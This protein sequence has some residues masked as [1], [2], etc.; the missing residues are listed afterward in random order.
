MPLDAD[1]AAYLESRRG[2][3]P[4]RSMTI[5]QTRA[6]LRDGTG[7]SAPMAEVEEA[8]LARC[9][10][11]Q[12]WPGR[13]PRLPLLVY[14]HGGRFIS[15]GLESHDSLCRAIAARSGWRVAA[16]DYR[17][18]PEHPFP[19]AVEDAFAA[20]EWA[21][22]Q[23]STVAIGGDSAGAN[24][25][26]VAAR[27][28]EAQVLVYPMI[29]AVCSLPSHAEFAAEGFGPGS[30]DMRRGWDLYLPEAT[31]RRDPLVS[32]LYATALAELPP[33]LVLTA[34]YDPLRD[35]GER[36]AAKLREARVP[37]ALHRYEGS[38]HG[39][40]H[41]S[42]ALASGRDALGRV[43]EFLVRAALQAKK[44]R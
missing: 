20:V 8:A 6:A 44:D 9:R 22:E 33:A 15:G 18:A 5:E 29:D 17:L 14:L 43:A 27:G 31:D 7:D 4:R 41:L 26:A 32:P 28:T 35:E 19:A 16:V 2:Q 13:D 34:G 30:E 38:I 40:F 24:L 37:V 1:V 36:Y 10:V 11:R 42:G 12:Y 21:R 25:A 23:S 3:P 39:F